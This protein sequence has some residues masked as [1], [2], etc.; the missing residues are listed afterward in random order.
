MWQAIISKTCYFWPIFTQNEARA[1]GSKAGAQKLTI[2]MAHCITHVVMSQFI[3]NMVVMEKTRKAQKSIAISPSRHRSFIDGFAK[4]FS[5]PVAF[6]S[7]FEMIVP[8]KF[9]ASPEKAWQDIGQTMRGVMAGE[10]AIKHGKN[11]KQ[12][13][14]KR[15]IAA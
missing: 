8:N 2:L 10:S 14:G 1:I 11:S 4:G 9:D 13:S 5:L 12:I 6:F 7:N 15:R 3:F